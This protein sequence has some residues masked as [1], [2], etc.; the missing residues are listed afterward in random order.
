MWLWAA[1]TVL[2]SL[3]A[4]LEGAKVAAPSRSRIDLPRIET[5]ATRFQL[6]DHDRFQTC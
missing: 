1:F 4:R 5:I 6:A 3:G 2:F